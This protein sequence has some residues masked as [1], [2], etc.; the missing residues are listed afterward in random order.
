MNEQAAANPGLAQHIQGNDMVRPNSAFIA[1]RVNQPLGAVDDDVTIDSAMA[2][3]TM[4]PD[5]LE[6]SPLEAFEHQFVKG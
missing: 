3:I 1:L 4:V 6:I 5:H 2:R